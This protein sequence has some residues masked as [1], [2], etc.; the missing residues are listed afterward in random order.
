V[1]DADG[2]SRAGLNDRE[3]GV[4]GRFSKCPM[5]LRYCALR[6]DASLVA[7]LAAGSKCLA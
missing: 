7:A 5:P 2:A 6:G 1:L 4:I 3:T